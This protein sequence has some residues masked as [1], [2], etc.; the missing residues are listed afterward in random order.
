MKKI[1]VTGASGFIGQPL[2]ETLPKLGRCVVAASRNLNTNLTNHNIKCI[3]VGDISFKKNWKDVLFE[4]DCIIHCAG[5]AHKMNNN[6]NFDAYQLTNINGTKL[7]AEQAVETGVKRLIFLSTIG[8]NGL[9]TN[10]CNLFTNF[11]KPNP[12]E[13]YSISKYQAEKILLDISNK[14]ALEVVIIRSPLVYGRFA[15]GNLKRLIKLIKLGIPL[16]FGGIKNKRSLIGIDNL[17]D[18]INHCIDHPEASGKTFLASDGEDFSTP[19]LIKLITS[20][21]G[22]KANLFPL[23]FLILKF[24]SSIIGKSEELNKLA[25][26]L[27]IDNSYTKETLGWTPPLSVKEGIRRM[28]QVK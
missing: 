6:K 22:K 10:N 12:V 1:L 27:R 28:V 19:Q 24:L 16:P 26:S 11:D 4:V 13:N 2:C 5:I 9:N 8:V 25:G 17:I 14:T 3:S 7:L 15:V 23:P 21:M 18:L 20:S